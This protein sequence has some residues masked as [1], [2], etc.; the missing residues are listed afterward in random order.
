MR[1]FASTYSSVHGVRPDIKDI[2]NCFVAN[3]TM[4]GLKHESKQQQT[5]LGFLVDKLSCLLQ[6]AN[7]DDLNFLKN[8]GPAERLT[9]IYRLVTYLIGL[10]G[11]EGT[12]S[13]YL[14]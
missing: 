7:K 9:N 6:S 1:V 5:V 10:K 13:F 14:L 12:K 3:L 8:S 11:E 4:E 2:Q